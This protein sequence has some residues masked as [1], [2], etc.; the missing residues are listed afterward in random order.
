M[1]PTRAGRSIVWEP[2]V[3]TDSRRLSR[4]L[5]HWSSF[6]IALLLI[7]TAITFPTHA[8][9]D[10]GFDVL[11]AGQGEP[12]IRFSNGEMLQANFIHGESGNRASFSANAEPVSVSLADLDQDGSPE[13]IAGYG[14]DDTGKL[15]VFR[16]NPDVIYPYT[17]DYLARKRSGEFYDSPFFEEALVFDLDSSP[18]LIGVGDFNIDGH[19]D[20]VTASYNGETLSWHLGQGNGRIRETLLHQVDGQITALTSG[21]VNR[22]DGID[23]VLVAIESASGAYLL[24]LEGPGGAMQATVERIS[25]P[26]PATQLAIGH[27]DGFWARD[28]VALCG[29]QLFMVEGRDR[30]LSLDSR[31]RTSVASAKTGTLNL[32]ATGVGLSLGDYV[33]DEPFSHEIAVLTDDGKLEILDGGTTESAF[34]P[35]NPPGAN[36]LLWET[37]QALQFSSFEDASSQ[38]FASP[39]VTAKVSSHQTEDLLVLDSDRNKIHLLSPGQETL[40]SWAM[41]SRPQL[42]L[43]MRLNIDGIQDIVIFSEDSVIPVIVPSQAQATITVNDLGSGGDCLPDDGICAAGP[44]KMGVC[45]GPCTLQAAIGHANSTPGADVINFSVQGSTSVSDAVATET[46]TIDGTPISGADEPVFPSPDGPASP[47][48]SISGHINLSGSSSVLRRVAIHNPA[49]QVAIALNGNSSLLESSYIGTDT[50]GT[51]VLGGWDGAHMN[52]SNTLIGGPSTA[53]RN[54]F[55]GNDASGI[56][57]FGGAMSRIERQLFWDG[58]VGEHRQQCR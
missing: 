57:L 12:W 45:Q 58:S 31:L 19:I 51:A 55:A 34:G 39:L 52:S 27:L 53:A 47:V 28:I 56:A 49:V 10:A 16:G 35:K 50:T 26:A 42:A 7:N 37:W 18:D 9:G 29:K 21:E 33:A 22:R 5:T 36:S 32:S 25:L 17:P 44:E 1:H 23:D 48:I 20:V 2:T 38:E 3:L 43:P 15:V 41:S 30:K 54:T 13:L 4:P 46:L 24:V 14:D 11:S 8:S 6:A 40:P